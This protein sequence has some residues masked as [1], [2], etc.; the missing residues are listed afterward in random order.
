MEHIFGQ[1]KK[2]EMAAPSRGAVA[3][4]KADLERAKQ[5][6]DPANPNGTGMAWTHNF[7]NQ[8]PWHPMS[9]RNRMKVW[10]HQQAKADEDKTKDKAKAEFDA[11]QEYLKT[12]SY[13]S[14]EEQQRYR[15]VQSV[16]FMYQK[17]PGLDA[18]LARDAEAEKKKVAQPAALPGPSGAGGGA[19]APAAGAAPAASAAAAPA[20]PAPDPGPSRAA[21]VDRLREDPYAVMLAAQ[22]ALANNPKFALARPR[23]AGAFGGYAATASNQQLLGEEE[24]PGGGDPG[25]AELEALLALPADQQ[26]KVLKR[27]ARKRRKEEEE[28]KLREAE[29]VLRAA[30]YDLSAMA[31][32]G[33]GGGSGK[34]KKKSKSKGQKRKEGSKKGK[35][36]RRTSDSG[37]SSGSESS[38][39]K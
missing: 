7:L 24:L 9:F 17:P 37:S 31:G 15:E 14:P 28:R 33:G 22:K 8:K 25:A 39:S 1:A 16:S 21:L 5:G 32:A 6:Y 30:G 35:K 26:L 20:A 10:E 38:G 4:V 29:E 12:L 13:L 11:E 23:D 27:I 19:A 34:H 3:G 36:R 18:A 2:K